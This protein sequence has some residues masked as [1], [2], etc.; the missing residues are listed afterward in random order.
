MHNCL[1]VGNEASNTT[2]DL[3]I[4]GGVFNGWGSDPAIM[5]LI[6]CTLVGNYAGY[7]Y[8]GAV[9]ASG[10]SDL[11]VQNGIVWDNSDEGSDALD[12]QLFYAA[13]TLNDDDVD[14]NLIDDLDI[15]PTRFEQSGNEVNK[16]D[17]PVFV[18]GGTDKAWTAVAYDTDTGL[19]TFTVT[20]ITGN[21]DPNDL[22]YQA[23]PAKSHLQLLIK[24]I[25]AN[26]SI[27]CYGEWSGSTATG[28]IF[29]YHIDTGTG[30]LNYGDSDYYPADVCELDPDTIH[31]ELRVDLDLVARSG[32]PDSGAYEKD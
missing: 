4:G 27:V 7:R 26:T 31:N 14:H 25:V 13:N 11:L 16:E 8:G 30:A 28:K 18:D 3:D 12:A 1:I 10:N 2:N 15:A 24:V 29:D 6:N 5:D 9:N 20:S 21:S 23:D 17:D 22:F 32:D 19:T